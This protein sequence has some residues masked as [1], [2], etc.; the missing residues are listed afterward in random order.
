QIATI[1]LEMVVGLKKRPKSYKQWE[2]DMIHITIPFQ[3]KAHN[4][5]HDLPEQSKD[6]LERVFCLRSYVLIGDMGEQYK[7]LEFFET[8]NAY[9]FLLVWA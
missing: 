3:Y 8:E 5:Y 1:F 9:E 2:E 6:S 4:Y 7:P